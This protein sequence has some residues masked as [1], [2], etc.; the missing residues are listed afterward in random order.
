[1]EN[2]MNIHQ[3][4]WSDGFLGVPETSFFRRPWFIEMHHTISIISPGYI[5][6]RLARTRGL[7]WRPGISYFNFVWPYMPFD[8][9]AIPYCVQVHSKCQYT[10]TQALALWYVHQ[11]WEMSGLSTN[12]RNMLV[13]HWNVQVR[14]IR[15]IRTVML[16]IYGSAIKRKTKELI[17][18]CFVLKQTSHGHAHMRFVILWHQHQSACS[19]QL[20]TITPAHILETALLL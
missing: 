4:R 8:W 19:I 1:M 14:K 3:T 20:S 10:A 9:V 12:Y 7:Y 5:Y 6:F 16:S 2:K 15:E 18:V 13:R 17:M 11:P